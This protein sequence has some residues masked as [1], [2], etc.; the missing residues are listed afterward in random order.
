LL[1]RPADLVERFGLAGRFLRL[2]EGD[3]FPALER[4]RRLAGAL[5][6]LDSSFTFAA[7]VPR[8]EP[9][10]VAT[11]VSSSSAAPGF[12]SSVI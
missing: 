5:A 10:V 1:L 12:C 6:D 9:I 4:G 11:F 2:A 8:A 3:F 7:T